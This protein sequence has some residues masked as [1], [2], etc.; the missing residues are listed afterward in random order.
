MVAGT[1]LKADAWFDS[2]GIRQEARLEGLRVI[3]RR[4]LGHVN[5]VVSMW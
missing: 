3:Q 2:K 1:G 4:V 5:R